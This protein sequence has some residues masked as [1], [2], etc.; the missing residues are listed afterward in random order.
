MFTH[1][2]EQVDSSETGGIGA[3]TAQAFLTETEGQDGTDEVDTNDANELENGTTDGH[4]A[5][6]LG[7]DA[8][9]WRARMGRVVV[10]AMHRRQR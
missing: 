5:S 4:T 3:A 9:T 2:Y 8:R 6:L 7:R 10:V 1:A